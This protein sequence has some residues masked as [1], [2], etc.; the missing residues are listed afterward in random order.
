MLTPDISETNVHYL[1]SPNKYISNDTIK[2]AIII[3]TQDITYTL[4]VTDARGCVTQDEIKVKE[5]DPLIIP[6]TFTP[7]DDGINDY[8]NIPIFQK[9]KYFTVNIFNRYG[10][11]VFSSVGYGTPWDGTYNGKPLPVGTYYYIIDP[12]N[13]GNKLTGS[14]TILR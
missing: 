10:T 8:W 7:N 2:N 11:L 12:K 4:T 9:N 6:N 13:G 1:W 5:L 14:V 3:G